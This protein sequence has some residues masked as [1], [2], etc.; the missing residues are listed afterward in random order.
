MTKRFAFIV[1]ATSIIA[2]YISLRFFLY[3][4]V[5]EDY[6]FTSISMIFI[7]AATFAVALQL[8]LSVIDFCYRRYKRF[9]IIKT[10]EKRL[11]KESW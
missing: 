8:F 10:K 9:R 2:F 1:M 6:N 7:G 11:K 3:P 5:G 4:V